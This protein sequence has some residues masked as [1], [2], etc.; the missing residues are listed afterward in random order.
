MAISPTAVGIGTGG[1]QVGHRLQWLSPVPPAPAHGPIWAPAAL[2]RVCILAPE[3]YSPLPNPASL[4][5]ILHTSAFPDEALCLSRNPPF[6]P[7]PNTDLILC[8]QQ[9]HFYAACPT[10]VWHAAPA[11]LYAGVL[12]ALSRPSQSASLISCRVAR[13]LLHTAARSTRT[14][15]HWVGKTFIN[16]LAGQTQI[17]G[18]SQ[19][20]C[21]VIPH[22][23]ERGASPS[24]QRSSPCSPEGPL[25]PQR[26][27]QTSGHTHGSGRQLPAA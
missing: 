11:C 8:Q 9:K 18:G 17:P 27:A 6:G 1:S 26:A 23:A 25:S 4:C 5:S 13:R 10:L 22:V 21:R 19:L 12:I 7:S 15:S 3:P 16:S 2:S 14:L 24:A 20:T